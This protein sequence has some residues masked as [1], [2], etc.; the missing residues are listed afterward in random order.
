MY[1]WLGL[2]VKGEKRT[3]RRISASVGKGRSGSPWSQVEGAAIECEEEI[4]RA[5][6]IRA[7]GERGW[8]EEVAI[9]LSF[10]FA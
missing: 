2:G 8:A 4:R 10:W 1:I 5:K 7:S 9:D 3:P 6:R